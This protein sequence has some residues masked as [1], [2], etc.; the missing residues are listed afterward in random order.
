MGGKGESQSKSGNYLQKIS[1]NQYIPDKT[2]QIDR[3][4]SDEN[5]STPSP[6]NTQPN[7]ENNSMPLIAQNPQ[8]YENYLYLIIPEEL[9][10][11]LL[12]KHRSK[13]LPVKTKKSQKRYLCLCLRI[14]SRSLIILLFPLRQKNREGEGRTAACKTY[15]TFI[16]KMFDY[17]LIPPLQIWI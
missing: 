3:N 7:S 17:S 11:N 2:L 5:S 8:N 14:L 13:P 4:L 1:Q 10:R 16:Q 9:E 15:T 6:C 12:D